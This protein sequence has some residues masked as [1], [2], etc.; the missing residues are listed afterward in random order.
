MLPQMEVNVTKRDCMSR[1]P[2]LKLA[3]NK[4]HYFPFKEYLSLTDLYNTSIKFCELDLNGNCL[5]VLDDESVNV[6]GNWTASIKLSDNPWFCECSDSSESVY[7][8]LSDNTILKCATPEYLKG[9]SC[10]YVSHTCRSTTLILGTD[11]S[12]EKEADENLEQ[13]RGEKPKLGTNSESEPFR[14]SIL[15]FVI[16]VIVM[17]VAIVVVFVIIRVIGKP[18]PD[19]FWWE[20]KLAKRNYY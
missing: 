18:E 10:I 11:S 12:V 20:D 2:S 16:Y 1:I 15:I 6:L 7:R 13:N 4:I 19:E 3:K 8:I 14:A 5:S 17:L 9:K